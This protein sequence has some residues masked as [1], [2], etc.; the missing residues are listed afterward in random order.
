MK[1][2]LFLMVI[3]VSFATGCNKEEISSPYFVWEGQFYITTHEPIAENELSEKIGK[4]REN[5]NKPYEDGQAK[6]LPE[7]TMLLMVEGQHL[8]TDK[9]NDGIIAFERDGEFNIAR[10]IEPELKGELK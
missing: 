4:I 7:G 2:L 8:G 10:Q 3:I 9:T 5:V 1:R 6:G